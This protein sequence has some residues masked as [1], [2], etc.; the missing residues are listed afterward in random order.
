VKNRNEVERYLINSCEDSND[1]KLDILGW[2]KSNA[3]K[4]KILL[5]IAQHVLASESTF[6]TS[7]RILNQFQSSLSPATVQALICCQN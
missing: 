7:G 3:S 2:W 1:N 6:S 5:K 4:Y